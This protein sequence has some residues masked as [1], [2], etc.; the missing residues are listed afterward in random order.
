MKPSSIG[1][2]NCW[3]CWLSSERR[4]CVGV[5]AASL[6]SMASSR[7]F[8]PARARMAGK[9]RRKKSSRAASHAS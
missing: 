6:P 3:S 7:A 9:W 2:E 4:V 8:E 1:V 5:S